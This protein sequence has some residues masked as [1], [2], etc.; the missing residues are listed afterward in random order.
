VAPF[1]LDHPVHL[2]QL[3]LGWVTI[4][5]SIGLSYSAWSIHFLAWDESKLI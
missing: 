1:F 2:N 3:V 5:F 4:R